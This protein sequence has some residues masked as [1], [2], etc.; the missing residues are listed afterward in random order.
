MIMEI[1]FAGKP[2]KQKR[3]NFDD[4]LKV[5]KDMG[6]QLLLDESKFIKRGNS[7]L[8][9]IGVE[10]WGKGFLNKKGI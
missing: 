6:F 1:M 2:M 7:R 3:K 9:V 4:M 5:Q 8:A 10:N